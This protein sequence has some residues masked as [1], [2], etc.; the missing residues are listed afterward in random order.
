MVSATA[1]AS[2]LLMMSGVLIAALLFNKQ[3]YEEQ[4][5]SRVA[6]PSFSS[7]HK[8]GPWPACKGM[9]GAACCELIEGYAVDIRGQCFIIP[10]NSPVTMDFRS[11]RV[12]VFV[13][14]DNVVTSIPSRG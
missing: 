2:V 1:I 13:D 11:T 5:A 12:R 4:Q 3:S 10:E 14:N 6:T 9:D 8:E 7:S